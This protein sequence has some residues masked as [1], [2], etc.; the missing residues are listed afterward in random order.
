MAR[1]RK[2]L[3]VGEVGSGVIRRADKTGKRHGA[4][5][6]SAW[7][8]VVGSDIAQ[9]TRGFALREKR[10]LVVF[11]D[12]AAW[13]N[14]LTLMSDELLVRLNSHLGEKSVTTLRFTVSR[15]VKDELVWEADTGDVDEFYAPDTTSPVPLDET[16]RRQLEQAASTV[17]N[18]ELRAIVLRVMTKDMELKKGARSRAEPVPRNDAP[19]RARNQ[20]L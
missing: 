9:H 11:V 17:K 2:T 7:R 5:A 15:K 16:E 14:Q 1:T 4:A 20:G 13:A 10:E 6:V 3:G 18:P 19:N 8:E 12:S